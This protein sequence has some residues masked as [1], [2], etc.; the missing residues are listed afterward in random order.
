MKLHRS[1]VKMC[2]VIVAV[3]TNAVA[4]AADS[5]TEIPTPEQ[6]FATRP[7]NLAQLPASWM[8]THPV[9]LS[10][11]FNLKSEPNSAKANAFL[12]TWYTSIKA[13]PDKVDLRLYRQVMPNRFAYSVSLTFA[14]WHDYI[15]YE[16][17][18]AFLKYYREHW[19]LEVTEAE[20]RLSILDTDAV[21][22][23]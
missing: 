2:L 3:G 11:S 16:R 13:L 14:N 4:Y 17:S 20:E 23:P 21:A 9:H 1:F 19:K 5:M 6:V 10:V 15:A 18:E 12:R 7:N 22:S 8:T